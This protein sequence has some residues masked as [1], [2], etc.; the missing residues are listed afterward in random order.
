MPTSFIPI[1]I[2]DATTYTI[3]ARNS[4]LVH[5]FP[6]FSSTCVATL[7][8]PKAGMNFEFAYNGLAADAANFT[9]DSGSDTYYFKGGLAFLDTDDAIA[10]IA[11]DGNSNSKMTIVVPS[12]G[13]RFRVESTDGTTW[14]VSGFVHSATVPSF[15][16]Q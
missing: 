8:T 13:T 12:T 11:G 2:P 7:P 9:I 4:G 14:N 15:A 10:V 5:Y 6:D 3:L 1:S 16:D